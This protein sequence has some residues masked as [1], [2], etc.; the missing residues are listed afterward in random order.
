[1]QTQAVFVY[2][3]FRPDKI[4]YKLIGRWVRQIERAATRG[5]L[6]DLGL[7]PVMLPGDGIVRGTLL[8]VADLDRTLGVLDERMGYLG[9]GCAENRFE[10]VLVAV[11]TDSGAAWPAYVYIWPAGRKTEL[12]TGAAFVP[13]GDWVQWQAGAEQNTGT[14]Q[15]PA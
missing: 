1:M 8:T 3:S 5:D 6:Y 13:G 9:P 11:T 4:N 12:P 2:G 15:L 10:R 14:S 7:Y